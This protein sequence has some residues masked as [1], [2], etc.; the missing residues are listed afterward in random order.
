MAMLLRIQSIMMRV[1]YEGL[2][3]NFYEE[4]FGGRKK[5]EQL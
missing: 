5:I 2:A 1:Y 4:H 3:L